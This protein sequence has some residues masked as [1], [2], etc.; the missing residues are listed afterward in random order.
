MKALGGSLTDRANASIEAGCDVLLHCSGFLKEADATLAE[1][2][3]VA[4]AAPVLEG[5]ALERAND[6][7]DASMRASAF[8]A[9]AGWEQFR[10]LIPDIGVTHA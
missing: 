4:Q 9:E 10:A 7:E 5:K 2:T 1:M 8:D 3:E 6:A